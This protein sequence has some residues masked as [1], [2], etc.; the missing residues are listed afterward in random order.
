MDLSDWP[1]GAHIITYCSCP[2]DVSALKAAHILSQRGLQVR[3]LA[4]GIDGWI[5]AGHASEVIVYRD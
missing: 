5:K 1:D 3:A 4:G 2:N